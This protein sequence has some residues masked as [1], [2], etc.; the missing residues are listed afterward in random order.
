MRHVLLHLSLVFGEK[1]PTVASLDT[2][3]LVEFPPLWSTSKDVELCPPGAWS[4]HCQNL[5][6]HY[7]KIY[8]MVK[9]PPHHGGVP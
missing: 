2:Q 8:T 5:L 6:F 1:F 4:K 3:T 7:N 9:H